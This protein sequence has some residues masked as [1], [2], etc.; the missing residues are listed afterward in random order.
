M[1][2]PLEQ[3]TGIGQLAAGVDKTLEALGIDGHGS[4]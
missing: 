2:S 1:G 3:A 4:P